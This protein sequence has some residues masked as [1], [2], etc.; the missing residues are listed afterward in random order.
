[1]SSGHPCSP[2]ETINDILL[3]GDRDGTP[4]KELTVSIG[5]CCRQ[6]ESNT[7]PEDEFSSFLS[8]VHDHIVVKDSAV[9]SVLLRAIR[10]GL[11]SEHACELLIKHG[12]HIL[13]VVSLEKDN[14]FSW[15]RMQ[16][17]KLINKFMDLS[18][19]SFPLA[20][21]RSLVAV[22][23][24]K[25]D[26]FRRV[27]LESLR[28]LGIKNTKVAYEAGAFRV[29]F[30]AILDPT[31]SYLSE[32]IL[33]TML[34]LLNSPNT[35]SFVRPHLDLQCL[36]SPFTDL[37][38]V[39][40]DDSLKR[41]DLAKAALV[42]MMR[43]FGGVVELTSD[44]M[45]LPAVV[46][47][48]SDP[49][50]S[51]VVKDAILDCIMEI[52][53][54]VINKLEFRKAH[55]AAHVVQQSQNSPTA[56]A[57]MSSQKTSKPRFVRRS[58]VGSDSDRVS[59]M[60]NMRG[61]S[62][63]DG[64][65]LTRDTSM[66][67]EN[68]HG[69]H[70]CRQDS[71]S[72]I[73]N[74]E[75]TGE[76]DTL[77][78][79]PSSFRK[80]NAGGTERQSKS[81]GGGIGRGGK[82]LSMWTRFTTH[83]ELAEKISVDPI[84]NMLDNYAA[85]ICCSFIH[86]RLFDNLCWLCAHGDLH[87]SARCKDVMVDLMGV[88]SKV[89]T[90]RVCSELL[91]LPCLIEYAASAAAMKHPDRAY[92]AS[93][94]LIALSNAFSLS[95]SNDTT[96]RQSSQDLRSSS[97][98]SGVT[99]SRAS[100][101][102]S[103][104]TLEAVMASKNNTS[105]PSQGTSI[106]TIS[107]EL[108]Q[109]SYTSG[110]V[111]SKK[112]E[113][114]HEL[115]LFMNAVI[116][117]SECTRQME[118]SRILGKE[119]KEPFRWDWAVINDLLDYSLRNAD[120]LG[121]A[122][123]TK[124]IKRLSGFYR[125]S[126]EEK[127]YFANL[128]WEP[129]H[130]HYLECACN[131]YTI[132]AESDSGL[133]FL[134]HDRRGLLFAELVRDLEA[135][136]TIAAATKTAQQN[137]Q[138]YAVPL[139]RHSQV[140]NVFRSAGCSQ[141]MAREYFCVMG[142]LSHSP[143][144]RHLLNSCQTYDHLSRL[145]H[146]ASLDYL[147]RVAL[148]ALGFTDGGFMSKDLLQI[149]T[150]SGGTSPDLRL[151]CHTLLRA[152]L[153]SRSREVC[154]WGMELMVDQLVYP[155][156]PRKSIIRCLE[157]AAQ[158]REYLKELILKEP[159]IVGDDMTNL[160]IR[161][162]ALPEGFHYLSALNWVEKELSHWKSHK[163]KEYAS[164]VELALAKGL[165]STYLSRQYSQ[166]VS[167]IPVTAQAFS[168]HPSAPSGLQYPDGGVDIE[169][170]LRMPWNIE[171]KVTGPSGVEAEYVKVDTYL[172]SS[173]LGCPASNDMTSD[174]LRLVKVRGVVLDKQ[175]IPSGHA[176]MNDRTLMSALLCGVCPVKR[177]GVVMPSEERS[178]SSSNPISNTT[179]GDMRG[180]LGN[181]TVNHSIHRR[182]KSV[183]AAKSSY[184]S[185]D[186]LGSVRGSYCE[187]APEWS[188]S[189]DVPLTFLSDHLQDW[190]KC[191]PSHRL[192]LRQID[193]PGT[194]RFAVEI[195]GEPTVFIFSRNAP[196]SKGSDRHAQ[197][198]IDSRPQ[199]PSV[200]Y[201]VEVHYV[202]R[203]QTGQAAF[204]PLPRHMYGEL[205]RTSAGMKLMHSQNIIPDLLLRAQA[206]STP[207]SDVIAALWALGHISSSEN[208]IQAIIAIDKNFV[209]WCIE[210]AT[211]NRSYSVRAV[212]FTVLGLISRT[213]KGSQQLSS[214]G[215]EAAPIHYIAVA[216]PKDPSVLFESAINNSP[217]MEHM[218]QT[219]LAMSSP[220][221]RRFRD[222]TTWFGFDGSDGDLESN[223]LQCIAKLPGQLLYKDSYATLMKYHTSHSEMFQS[224]KLYMAV[225]DIL[226]NYTFKLSLRRMIMGLFSPGA[227]K[228]DVVH[229]GLP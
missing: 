14:D 154:E 112:A 80:T 76:S 127:G 110:T 89:C 167:P 133:G 49:N 146:Y 64:S 153:R 77:T 203:L 182:R 50:V 83:A 70:T 100:R 170:L 124:F 33:M 177:D 56:L 181:S 172:D 31:I 9:R 53:E 136:L 138:V 98:H 212:A 88:V 58:T 178:T 221:H 27:V 196:S 81:P 94:M 84:Y 208:G 142:R 26:N 219:E 157:E 150:T 99:S 72:R 42:T 107:T 28:E 113:M 1:M 22:S 225:H 222:T 137:G 166:A 161:F 175:G 134:M 46:Q 74:D 149:Y 201:L 37:D 145:G 24:E 199:Q 193:I 224:R 174:T 35:R 125:C 71:I 184:S 148:T 6:L 180:S 68:F 189:G 52:F 20:F 65:R 226:A 111:N 23:M 114:I 198:R 118:M 185:P 87:I 139:S 93:D 194:D 168:S 164:R 171:V 211:E 135:V 141:T 116:D 205:S 151:Y 41:W 38:T 32:S 12:I 187:P 47:L 129:N 218:G 217:D 78:P 173:E 202:L 29:L 200:A 25:S 123:K 191:K 126:T 119:G 195:S 55:G 131:L 188:T 103:G 128:E 8:E 45:G 3:K 186:L 143:Q 179:S 57:A 109:T 106:S 155:H 7:F 11:K 169:G 122:L 130:L 209:A 69:A 59:T 108:V 62:N 120:R 34:Y 105:G 228:A 220:F 162:L 165:N 82:R 163:C 18:P 176:V 44:R 67:D 95:K 39:R 54:P 15:E 48:L 16:A 204:L 61:R 13:V 183:A 30:D 17:L 156:V 192:K 140:L 101:R 216:V 197:T 210:I 90:E 104:R 144:G 214:C 21:A 40:G 158:D 147:S 97:S 215:W 91:T 4:S 160:L 117:K 36:L 96:Y 79:L 73:I 51:A 86:V 2:L 207:S 190:T 66:S 132:L 75:D 63:T 43:S 19:D 227:K 60:N 85:L 121:E 152:L 92:K 223:I 115:K 206:V 5:T 102:F 159:E 10:Y 213:E 229:H